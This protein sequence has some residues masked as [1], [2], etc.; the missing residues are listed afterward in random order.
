MNVACLGCEQFDTNENACGITK[1]SPI[2]K[3][4]IASLKKRCAGKHFGTVVDVGCGGWEFSKELFVTAG[5]EWFGVDP[6]PEG[7]SGQPSCRTHEG[8]IDSIP[9]EN[10][11]VDLIIANQSM[12]HWFQ[13]GTSFRAGL[14]EIHRVLK[15]GGTAILNVPIHFH[16]HPIF[17][18]GNYNAI[19]RLISKKKWS[20]FELV[21]WGKERSPDAV[22][23]GWLLNRKVNEFE[24]SFIPRPFPPNS[25]MLEII[26]HKGVSDGRDITGDLRISLVDFRYM[27]KFKVRR[28]FFRAKRKLLRLCSGR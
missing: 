1:A 13:Y 24:R 10:Q 19:R 28:L 2:R 14:R 22:W 5:N 6:S 21:D 18:E 17:I 11:T 26:L 15:D 12:E 25:Y 23:P 7:Y 20:K 9:F 3:C 4:V 8:T 27:L 16:G